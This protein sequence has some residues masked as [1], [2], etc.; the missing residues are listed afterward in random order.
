MKLS[1]QATQSLAI[2]KAPLEL[3]YG[4]GCY[5]KASRPLTSFKGVLDTLAKVRGARGEDWLRHNFT[6]LSSF[7]LA[8]D[9]HA[10]YS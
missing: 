6:N 2:D 7:P 3:L 9:P 1:V 5:S 8:V 10:R 4:S